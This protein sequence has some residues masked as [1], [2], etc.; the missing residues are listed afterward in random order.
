MQQNEGTIYWTTFHH[1]EWELVVAKTTKGLC[2]LGT[3]QETYEDLVKWTQKRLPKVTFI[4]NKTP[5]QP[6]IQELQA[7][8]AGK[9]TQFTLPLDLLGTEFQSRVWR[10][11][12]NI[13][14]GQTCTYSDIAQHINKPTGVR[15]VGRAI[16]AN[17]ILI[18]IPC[19]RVIG[20]NGAITGFRGGIPMK[21]YLLAL[22]REH[23][24]TTSSI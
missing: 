3:P 9:T 16:G 2:F 4:K 15:A 21:Q 17:P 8:F 13:P 11:L 1:Q 18:A 22:E 12:L 24:P 5:L 7:Y 14:Y 20:K 23:H 19:H 6:Y 10:A